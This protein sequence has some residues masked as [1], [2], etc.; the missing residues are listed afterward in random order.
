MN[1][2]II[3]AFSFLL[4]FIS[5]SNKFSLQKRKYRKGYYFASSLQ[6]N[7]QNA[8]HENRKQSINKKDKNSVA[9]KQFKTEEVYRTV[10]LTE[11]KSEKS[12]IATDKNLNNRNLN[13]TPVSNKVKLDSELKV[14]IKKSINGQKNKLKNATDY[15]YNEP[16]NFWGSLI[17]ILVLI[18]IYLAVD[19]GV[20]IS[21]VVVSY[22]LGGILMLA[23]IIALV[24]LISEYSSKS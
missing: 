8:N 19:A 18:G 7:T 2:R 23:F 15:W 9:L 22:I 12:S 3:I 20:T 4:V 16:G 10:K 14:E 21:L 17:L 11:V 1:S 5:C 13:Y 6:Q 24:Y